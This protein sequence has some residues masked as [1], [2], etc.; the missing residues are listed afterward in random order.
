MQ[1]TFLDKTIAFFSPASGL[2]RLQNKNAIEII[3]KGNKRG[4]E[5]ARR[6]RRTAGWQIIGEDAELATLDEISLIRKRSRDLYRN[7]PYAYK[8]HNS[9]ADNTTGT[10]ILP[11]I[12]DDKLKEVWRLWANSI[13][14]DYDRNLNFYGIQNLCM[15]TMSIQGNVLILRIKSADKKIPLELKII[16]AQ[17]LDESKDTNQTKSGGFI[18]GGIEFNKSGKRKG[19]WI[20][21]REPKV[22]GSTKSV[23][24]SDEDV[25]HLFQV[26]EPGQVLGVP[27]GASS[28][29]SLR[30]YDDYADAQLMRQ[31]IA[32][33]FS[34]FITKTDGEMTANSDEPE[35]RLEKIAPG[36]IEHLEPGKQVM[37]A[38]PPPAEGY[39]EYSRNVLGSVAAGFGVSYESMTG[40]LSNVNFSSGRM[41]WLEYQRRIENYQRFIIIPKLCNGVWRW[42][43]E[44]GMLSGLISKQAPL[45]IEWTAPG[46]QMIDPVKEVKGM[47]DQVRAGLMSWQE[48]V[49]KLGYSP[50]EVLEELKTSAK[51]FD[52]AGIK[53][54]VDPRYDKEQVSQQIDN[55]DT[56]TDRRQD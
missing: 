34:V 30:D 17:L 48:A 27:F 6:D 54:T 18:K 35:E 31:K 29:M 13:N 39:G 44:A 53:P 52:D 33:C 45:S 7:N 47:T 22:F 2:R 24:W 19:Y 11:A 15:K 16:T 50:E 14:A 42:F 55:A 10:G 40:D 37:F 3:A 49:R 20:F 5:A 41:G 43:V 1:L 25:I 56:D 4:Y 28:I 38:S 9:I 51:L 26:E 12:K 36:I 32:A 23:F 21:D 8:S 46:R